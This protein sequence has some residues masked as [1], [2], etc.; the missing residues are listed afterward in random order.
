MQDVANAVLMMVEED[1]NGKTAMVF[2]DRYPIIDD[3]HQRFREDVLK[4]DADEAKKR[5]GIMMSAAAM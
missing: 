3:Y 5:M 4:V 2:S 1:H